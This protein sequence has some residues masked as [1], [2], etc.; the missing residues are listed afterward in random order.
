MGGNNSKIIIG[1]DGKQIRPKRGQYRRYE[2]E[3]LAKAVAAVLS[4]EMSVHKA[5]SYFGVPHSTVSHSLSSPPLVPFDRFQLEYKVKERN[6][7]VSSSIKPKQESTPV[8]EN[9]TQ[10]FSILLD[11]EKALPPSNST[12]IAPSDDDD[13][14]DDGD[15]FEEPMDAYSPIKFSMN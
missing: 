6:I 4:N 5:G 1:T 7:K 11:D 14:D 3:Q 12:A 10:Q 13:D 8:N 15:E 2:S 9:S